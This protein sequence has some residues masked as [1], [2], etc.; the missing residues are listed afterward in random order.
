MHLRDLAQSTIPFVGA[1]LVAFAL[2]PAASS[3]V[4]PNDECTTSISIAGPGVFPFDLTLATR[5]PQTVPCAPGTI[6]HDVWFCW[7]SPCTGILS[8][9]TCGLATSDTFVLMYDGCFCPPE[10]LLGCNDDCCGV[11]SGLHVMVTAGSSYLLRVGTASGAGTPG[12]LRIACADLACVTT[13]PE[14]QPEPCPNPI[15]T[16]TL[17]TGQVESMP[18]SPTQLDDSIFYVT[19]GDPTQCFSDS[20]DTGSG[21]PF[22]AAV[23]S[24]NRATVVSPAVGAWVQS[25]TC[26]PS[27]RWI[28][29]SVGPGFGGAGLPPHTALY[30][31]PF[32]V[33]SFVEQAFISFCWAADDQLGDPATGPAPVGVYIRN[34]SGVVTPLPQL[35]G[36]G[37]AAQNGPITLAVPAGA[38]STGI[39]YLLVYQRDLRCYTSGVIYSATITI[40]G[41]CLTLFSAQFAGDPAE[42]NTDVHDNSNHPREIHHSIGSNVMQDGL[43]VQFAQQVAAN[44][45]LLTGR[46]TVAVGRA[47]Y[48]VQFRTNF[49][50]GEPWCLFVKTERNGEITSV[51][52]GHEYATGYVS[53]VT[54]SLL[55]GANQSVTL[56]SGT[57]DLPTIFTNTNRFIA[58][59]SADYPFNQSGYAIIQGV[60]PE[61]MTLNFTW[62]ALM[63]SVAKPFPFPAD[64]DSIGLR[65][66][67]HSQNSKICPGATWYQRF[68]MPCVVRGDAP[69]DNGCPSGQESDRCQGEDGHFVTITC[70]PCVNDYCQS[71]TCK[72]PEDPACQQMLDG[73]FATGNVVPPMYNPG[74]GGASGGPGDGYLHVRGLAAGQSPVLHAP[75]AFHGKW[76]CFCGYLEF[77]INMFSDGVPGSP[78]FYPSITIRRDETASGANTGLLSP[79]GYG[80][81]FATFVSTTPITD[82]AGWK[83]I[84]I[85][86][87]PGIQPTAGL[88]TWTFGPA[89]V[90]PADLDWLRGRVTDLSF[91]ADF[92]GNAETIG[93]DSICLVE[94]T[95]C[96]P[97]PAG[98]VGWWPFDE[99]TPAIHEIASQR[100][101]HPEPTQT[102]LG[103]APGFSNS[104][105]PVKGMVGGALQFDG[106]DDRVVSPAPTSTGAYQFVT[107]D[108]SIDAWIK[109]TA[110]TG[111]QPIVDKRAVYLS[112]S[113]PTGYR[114]FL[115]HGNLAFGL[116][117]L[118]LPG[119]TVFLST[120]L[121]LADGA[122][123]HVAV[124]V[125]RFTTSAG[126]ASVKL[127]ADC[128]IVGQFSPAGK[129]GYIANAQ[130]DLYIGAGHPIGG[131][132]AFFRGTID[133]VEIFRRAL[134]ASEICAIYSA[135]CA[136]KCRD[137]CYVGSHCVNTAGGNV[138]LQ[139]YNGSPLPKVF[140]WSAASGGSSSSCTLSSGLSFAPATASVWVP[141]YGSAPV[142]LH[143]TPP[144]G[145][146]AADRA[147]FT[148][149]FTDPVTGA[150]QRCEGSVSLCCVT[151]WK[152]NPSSSFLFASYGPGAQPLPAAFMVTNTGG[153]P[154]TISY[155][156]V[157]RS[158]DPGDNIPIIEL[159]HLPAGAPVVGALNLP[160]GASASV[161]LEV[162][163]TELQSFLPHELVI[164]V[165]PEG[166]GTFAEAAT[167]GL[168][169]R[170]A[171]PPPCPDEFRDGFD[172]YPAGLVCG[173]AGWEAWVG[174]ID[175][176]GSVVD[177]HAFDSTHS[178][179]I[180][181]TP[182]G[183][184]GRGDDTVHRFEIQGG[185]RILESQVFVPDTAAGTGWV[186]MLN[187]YPAPLNWSL[188][189]RFDA[190]L[191]LVSD[192][193]DPPHAVP[194][195]KGRWVRFVIDIDL[196]ADRVN[197]W[198]D[199][200]QFIFDKSWI[201][202]DTGGGQPRIQAL[203]L[204]AGEPG[205]GGTTGMYFDAISIRPALPCEPPDCNGNL[206]PD[207]A[208]IFEGLVTD[209]NANGVPDTCECPADWNHDG[210][211][212]S[213]DFFD[214][215]VDFF[216]NHADF[217]H[218]GLTNSQDFFDFLT[219]FFTPCP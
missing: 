125:K 132:A 145:M 194:L 211:V 113:S 198:Y 106:I 172:L 171:E 140:I 188:D 80:A 201:N 104:P 109:T 214:F 200:Q 58:D 73:W 76:D 53:G 152:F 195:A 190:D 141:A 48:D 6:D 170:A 18:G 209:A 42:F 62:D 50:P 74:A 52:D 146:T 202:G 39:N 94:N 60:G 66:G 10:T 29:W 116:A 31:Q 61:V 130:A 128:N 35:S 81:V 46:D 107:D 193:F 210:A 178:L 153:S 206:I 41:N 72:N 79:S 37:F 117:D 21:L 2:A 9:Q 218:D 34:G 165:D 205:A 17:R 26:D 212:N 49:P 51:D 30:S 88:G 71:F 136:G 174:S 154:S 142:T 215:L 103:G 182:G 63:Q 44:T 82:I 208:E 14:P 83:H 184:T 101:C 97:P 19:T 70:V 33:S 162:V 112:G 24:T 47:N 160:A 56:S 64:G 168:V 67:I 158:T 96:V 86:L 75:S 155:R 169:A 143:V 78:P 15:E 163:Y 69:D 7:T 36:G 126:P 65:M 159:N 204:Y 122:W 20:L 147:C 175:V 183:S 139:I 115:Q 176:C 161:P 100:P 167:M 187:T 85:P 25:L 95:N 166:D 189:I 197:A 216:E 22:A 207:V 4:P 27:A 156:I 144:P 55:T 164:E 111:E 99:K 54:G 89:G 32:V 219:A 5:S 110:A 11:Q 3:Q 185:H 91:V 90:T 203:D 84:R 59:N 120:P 43:R 119:E 40:C 13:P 131:P 127:Y 102:A 121:N 124:T 38:I 108:F 191:E 87:P 28:N 77:D 129:T 213:Q 68:G 12:A 105:A 180:V 192:L 150:I 181:G 179:R 135:G 134:S 98:L 133:E 148:I 16:I 123:H 93:F 157:A 196:D 217:N 137:W 149:T 118:A 186:V 138:T 1:L 173:H 199:D 57:L 8:V 151:P 114:L 23:A 177:D 45:R 92:N